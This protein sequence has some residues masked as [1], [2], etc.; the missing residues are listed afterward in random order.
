[1]NLL[2]VSGGAL[3]V[4]ARLTNQEWIL[5][6]SIIVTVLGMV[7]AYLENKENAS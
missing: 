5:I 3:I 2:K 6:I 4:T 7:Q 1:M